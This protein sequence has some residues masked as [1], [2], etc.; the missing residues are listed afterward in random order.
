MGSPPNPSHRLED[1]VPLPSL[2]SNTEAN[3]PILATAPYSSVIS[4]YI[5]PSKGSQRL[6]AVERTP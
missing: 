2:T 4:K 6:V 1:G 5:T 3:A